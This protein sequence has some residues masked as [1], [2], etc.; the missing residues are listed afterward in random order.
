MITTYCRSFVGVSNSLLVDPD[1]SLV[2]NPECEGA[3]DDQESILPQLR[4]LSKRD[5]D[6]AKIFEV[7]KAKKSRLMQGKNEGSNEQNMTTWIA[8]KVIAYICLFFK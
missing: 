1:I 6:F 2:T 8:T 7:L 5:A 3:V 4:E